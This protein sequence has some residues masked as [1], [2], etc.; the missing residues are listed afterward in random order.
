MHGMPAAEE[1]LVKGIYGGWRHAT[2]EVTGSADLNVNVQVEPSDSFISRIV[3]AVRNE[4]NVFSPS[5]GS[6]AGTAGSTGLSMPEAG[7]SP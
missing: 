6:G 7:P 3:Q 1:P 2:P 5:P 4:I